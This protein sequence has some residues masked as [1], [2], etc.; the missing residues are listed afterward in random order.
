M[1]F[2]RKIK[3]IF[4]KDFD[5]KFF[6]NVEE[7]DKERKRMD[8]RLTEVAKATL[9]GEDNWFLQLAKDD[10]EC[11]LNVKKECGKNDK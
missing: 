3:L 1:K 6:E 7:I 9:D 11:V 10:P 2:I 8:I 4:S 5:R